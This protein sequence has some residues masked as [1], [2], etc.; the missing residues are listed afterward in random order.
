MKRIIV[1]CKNVCGKADL[2]DLLESKLCLPDYFGRNLDA[3]HDILSE[4]NFTLELRSFAKLRESL[5][6]YADSLEAMLKATD[7]ECDG[8][9][10]V[11]KD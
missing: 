11:I 4:M 3:L 2:Y 1:N 7:E 9:R 5:G 10:A 6:G 8:F